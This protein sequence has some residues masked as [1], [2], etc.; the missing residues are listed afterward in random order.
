MATRNQEM[1]TAIRAAS[2]CASA[3]QWLAAQPSACGY[4]PCACDQQ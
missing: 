2:P 4:A 3:A 1:L